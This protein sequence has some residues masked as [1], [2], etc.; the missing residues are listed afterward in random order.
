MAYRND[1]GPGYYDNDDYYDGPYD[2]QPYQPQQQQQ[3]R[4]GSFVLPDM[5]KDFI[6]FFQKQ[7]QARNTYEI[8]VIYESAWPGLTEKFFKED[9]WPAAEDIRDLTGNDPTFAILYNELYFRHIYEKLNP[10]IE[11]RRD[12]YEN[13]CDLFNLI[14]HNSDQPDVPVNLELPNKW[15]WDIIDEFIYQF[16]SFSQFR[17]KLTNKT[18][19][20]INMLQTNPRLWNVHIVLNVLHSL[21]DKSNINEQLE[22]F[23]NGDNPNDVAGVFGEK[24]L[25][26]MLGYFSLVG[27]LRLHCLLGDY[28]Q[29]LRVMENIELNKKG[30]YSRVPACQVSVFYYVGFCYMMMGRYQDA[31]RTFSNILFYILR[32]QVSHTKNQGYSMINKK[33]DQLFH[34]LAIVMT[35]CPQR[36]DES[37]HLQLLE[38]CGDR[39]IR[40]GKRDDAALEELFSGGCPKFISSTAPNYEDRLKNQN[41]EP[42]KL[43]LKIFLAEI[44]QSLQLPLIRSYLKLYSTMPIEKLAQFCEDQSGDTNPASFRVSLHQYKHKTNQLAWTEGTALEGER[45]PTA[46]VDFYIDNDMIHIA[47]VKIERNFGEHFMHSI[48]KMSQEGI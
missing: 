47:D 15:L 13:Y 32:T 25:Y 3:P 39:M 38:R 5:V 4:G 24:Q 21:I 12:S 17:A 1:S 29:A 8:G 23:K 9:P 14:V 2:E 34:L 37:V 31:V 16:E 41:M 40:M 11:Q 42:Y 45:V 33:K 22:A 27:L 43:Q 10:T 20:E 44:R 36:I 7:V 6:V 26:K 18:E 46:D 28:Y 35:L 19:D 48:Y 30:L